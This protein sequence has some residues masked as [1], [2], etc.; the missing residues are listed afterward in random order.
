MTQI[1]D[2]TRIRHMLV[3]AR[4]TREL[5]EGRDRQDLDSDD[6]LG[7]ALVRLLEILGEAAGG[8]SPGVRPRGILKQAKG[9]G[10][11]SRSLDMPVRQSQ[12]TEAR[13]S[14]IARLGTHQYVAHYVCRYVD[15][16]WSSLSWRSM[17]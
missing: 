3:A 14:P 12:M 16:A 11:C 13:A 8:T 4:R 6:V 7:L 2:A 15:P 10:W 5:L 1:D 17:L 9:R